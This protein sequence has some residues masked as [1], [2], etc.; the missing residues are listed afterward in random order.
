[1]KRIS[2]P[3]W[4]KILPNDAYLGADEIRQVLGYSLKTSISQLLESKSIP[5]PD[6]KITGF[7]RPNWSSTKR[8]KWNVGKVREFI[9]E[10]TNE[11]IRTTS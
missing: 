5:L 9:K 7:N 8:P 1:M 2:V 4:F 11:R 10:K 3:D 6:I